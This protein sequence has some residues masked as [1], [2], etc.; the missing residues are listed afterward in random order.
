MV[1]DGLSAHGRIFVV[2]AATLG[3]GAPGSASAAH[4]GTNVLCDRS[5]PAFILLSDQLQVVPSR[6]L[7]IVFVA[8]SQVEVLQRNENVISARVDQHFRHDGVRHPSADLE[9]LRVL[10]HDLL[11]PTDVL[12]D[13]FLIHQLNAKNLLVV[14]L[15]L[16]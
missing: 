5:I 15:V 4:A 2:E 10:N 9:L 3:P 7:L 12:F 6:L 11:E 14:L 13:L 8:H 16:G 1:N